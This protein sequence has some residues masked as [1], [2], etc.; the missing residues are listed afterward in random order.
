MNYFYHISKKSKNPK[1][2]SNYPKKLGRVTLTKTLVPFFLLVGPF[3][4]FFMAK[5]VKNVASATQYYIHTL[6]V[7]Y[8]IL[9]VCDTNHCTE[10]CFL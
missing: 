8:K 6:L 3:F 7:L 4:G 5:N 1:F 9:K 10:S 2:Y